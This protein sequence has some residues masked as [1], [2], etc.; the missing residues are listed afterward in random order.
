MRFLLTII[1]IIISSF[2]IFDGGTYN[3]YIL[4]ILFI[5]QVII[6]SIALFKRPQ[7]TFSL[8]KLFHLFFLFFFCISP[9]IQFKES[10][11][12]LDT[13]F[14]DDIYIET[15]FLL[16]ICLLTYHLFYNSFRKKKEHA[17]SP[18]I[19]EQPGKAIS[20]TKEIMMVIFS[21]SIF[22]LILYKNNFNYLSIL[23]RGGEFVDRK[24]LSN[25][26][27]LI[28]NNFL[29]PMP[30]ILYLSTFYIKLRHRFIR[31]V[32][33]MIVFISC[34]PTG[35][36]R[37]AAAEIYLPI[38]LTSMPL[39]KKK[40]YFVIISTFG[41]L[42][43][44]PFLNNFR[45]FNEGTEL[46]VGLDFSQF[47]ELHFDTF[48]M[49]MRVVKDDIITYGQQLI[50]VFLFFIPRSIWPN[51]PIGSGSFVAH[52]TDLSFDNIS[53]P[54]FAEGYINFGFIGIILFTYLLAVITAKAD[55]YFWGKSEKKINDIAYLLFCGLLIFILRGDLM[56]S[57]SYTCGALASYVIIK[58][59]FF[60]KAFN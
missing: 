58:K 25:S 50:G 3:N 32:L 22:F 46:T 39:F 57:F 43:A 6:C 13:S 4:N 15:S 14:G 12:F 47:E 48:S 40:N 41:L 19:K 11:S 27:N 56:S 10:I 29:R 33:L 51:K 52:E 26:S 38:L 30:L 1:T 5:I 36:A 9:S 55:Q 44:F 17:P 31:Y 18:T 24:S 45:H 34:P 60:R 2:I 20:T 53:M 16:L 49:F 7:E 54:Y 21:I 28:L 35:M 23:F 8:Y 42:I 37:F 59:T